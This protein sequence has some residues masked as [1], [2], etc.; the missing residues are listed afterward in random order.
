MRIHS[1]GV[2]TSVIK[3]VTMTIFLANDP[4][5]LD[6]E[7]EYTSRG[8]NTFTAWVNSSNPS[9]SYLV[10]SVWKGTTFLARISHR[11]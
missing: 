9:D 6:R 8:A 3:L 7:L 4:N 10:R 11:V 1:R 2:G 5:W